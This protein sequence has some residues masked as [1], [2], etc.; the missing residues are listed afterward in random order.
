VKYLLLCAVLLTPGLAAGQTGKDPQLASGNAEL[1]AAKAA[2]WRS[3]FKKAAVAY[4]ASVETYPD[5]ADLWFNLGTAEAHAQRPG[6]ALHALEQA[7]RLDPEH[8]D[9]AHNLA[10]VRTQVIRDNLTGASSSRLILPGEDDLGT[11]LLTAVLPRTLTLV[12]SISWVLLFACLWGARHTQTSGRRTALVFGAVL[13]SLVAIGAG[14]LLM[15]RMNVVDETTYGVVIAE[16]IDAR[17]GPGTQY[18]AVVKILSGVKVR[19]SGADREWEQVV[20]PD[21]SGVWLPRTSV[22][23]LR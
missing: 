21:G 10:Q 4:R 13:M 17:Q 3:D 8:T 6:P 7:L 22:A 15:G 11:G 23:H 16:K 20:L 14:G 19:I 9:A 5:N 12:F 2:F 1:A 18:P